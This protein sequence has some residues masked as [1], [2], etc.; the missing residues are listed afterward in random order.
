MMWCWNL[1]NPRSKYV[2][3]YSFREKLNGNGRFWTIWYNTRSYKHQRYFARNFM[4]LSKAFSTSA[5]PILL[6]KLDHCGVNGTTLK[7]IPGYLTGRQHYVEIDGY[8][9]DSCTWFC[10][11][12]TAFIIHMYDIPPFLHDRPWISPW[13]KSISNELD[14]TC[15]VFASQ[16]SGHC[17]VIANRLWR[18][19]QNVKRAS[20]TRGWCVKILVFSV[21]YGFVMSC[22]K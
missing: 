13:I 7:W 15:H 14:I 5:R 6:D 3:Q 4:D 10:H 12:T 22:K 9:S 17:D 21:I 16:L 8:S 20:E 2:S 1:T 18:H 11:W 19:Q